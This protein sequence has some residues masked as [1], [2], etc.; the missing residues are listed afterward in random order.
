[1]MDTRSNLS[2]RQGSPSNQLSANELNML[3][4]PDF[5]RKKGEKV[6]DALYRDHLKRMARHKLMQETVS[7]WGHFRITCLLI[8]DD[9]LNLAHKYDN[10]PFMIYRMC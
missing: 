2:K 8:Y 6:D 4:E 3:Q 9:T 10:L 7:K 1:M 5:Y